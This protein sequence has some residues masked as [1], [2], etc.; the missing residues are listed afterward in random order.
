MV[1]WKPTKLGLKHLF[2]R[3]VTVQYPFEKFKV[4]PNYR[5]VPAVN[6]DTCTGCERCTDVCPN[7]CT[8]MV[9]HNGKRVPNWYGARCMFCYLCI[10]VCPTGARVN[11]PIY[12]LAAYSREATLWTPEQLDSIITGELRSEVPPQ[13]PVVKEEVCINCLSCRE[14]CPV[15]AISTT[16]IKNNRTFTLDYDTCIYCG[17]CINVCPPQALSYKEQKLKKSQR[18]EW[19]KFIPEKMPDVETYYKQLDKMVINPHFC[20]HCT[21]CIVSCPVNRI[22]GGDQEISED[23]DIPCTDCSLCVRV[24]P[25]YDYDNLKGLGDYIEHYTARST[26]FKGQDG[27]MATELFVTA[28]EMGII[29]TAIVVA[30]DDKW[31]PYLKIA[32][33]P[34]EILDGRKTKYALADILTALKEADRISKKGIGIIGVPCQIEGYDSIRDRIGYFTDKVKL[35]VGIFCTENFYYKRFYEEFIK[36][37][38]GVSPENLKSTD[39]KKGKLT[40]ISDKDEKHEIKLQD[41]EHYALLGCSICQHFTNL[42]ADVSIGGSGS[43][44]GWSSV[45]VRNENSKKVLE[46]MKEKGYIE[47]S[48]EEKKVQAIDKT[49][50]FMVKYKAKIHPIEPYLEHRGIKV[51]KK[52]EEKSG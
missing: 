51:E 40:V 23:M 25:R 4:G 9:E 16:D 33:D 30:S 46:H 1:V 47:W 7:K 5:G 44:L 20:S 2:R 8:I 21:A 45:Y 22:R 28:M 31:R 38:L 27:A 41:I 35:V 52:E 19:T 36:E 11:T 39:M 50:G 6:L 10:E 43:S 48:A 29:D 34:E 49:I 18:L 14:I 24:C 26:R 17:K 42:T 37:R 15:D 32:R 3:V 12:E 13:A